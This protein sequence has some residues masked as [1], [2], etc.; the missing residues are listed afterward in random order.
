[1]E[2]RAWRFEFATIDLA[3]STMTARAI[4][5]PPCPEHSPTQA[6]HGLF[7]WLHGRRRVIH[8]FW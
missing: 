3:M 7:I 5:L 6:N 1:M 2:K 8:C 4:P